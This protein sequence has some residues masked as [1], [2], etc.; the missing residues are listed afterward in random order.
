[1]FERYTDKARGAL[2]LARYE[3]SILGSSLIEA[4]HLLLGLLKEDKILLGVLRDDVAEAIRAEIEHSSPRGDQRVPAID[5]PFS[6]ESKRALAY[7]AEEAVRLGHGLIDCPHL[8]LGLLRVDGC[9][10]AN[11]LRVRGIQSV[12]YRSMVGG[13]PAAPLQPTAPLRPAA[14]WLEDTIATLENLV[15][16]TRKH[17]KRYADVYGEQRSQTD[18]P[19]TRK[20]ALGHLVDWAAA[21]HVWIARALTEPKLSASGYPPD[22]WVSAQKYENYVWQ[23]IVDLWAALNMLLIHVLAQIPE[24]KLG[25]ECRIGSEEPVPLSK[26][27]ERYVEHCEGVVVSILA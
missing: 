26:L 8:T 27:I 19:W 18:K 1:M 14:P 17:L 13:R 2:F 3:A 15:G 24:A 23:E 12:A 21:H 6:V 4:E 7:S 9:M 16:R 20:Q 25:L 10:A 5:L 11:L 22:S